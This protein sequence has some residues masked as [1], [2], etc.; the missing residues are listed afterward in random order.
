M[1]RRNRILKLW[2]LCS[3]TLSVLVPGR[4]K[5][6]NVS[7]RTNLAWDAVAEPNLGLE[8]QAGDHWSVGADAGLKAWP[9]WL[10]W[11]WDSNNTVHWRNFAVVPEVRYYFDQVFRGFFAG[12]DAVY[13]HYNVGNVQFPFGLYPEAKDYRLQGSF[14]GGGLFMGYAWW[15]GSHWRMELE[16]GAAG[17][18]AAYDRYDCAHC[19][20]KL[21]EERKVAVVPKLAVNVAWNP[22]SREKQMA[23]QPRQ[24]VVSGRDTIT[25]LTPPV[26]FVVQL[27]EVKA[28]MTVADSLAKENPWIIPIEKYRP[29]TYLDLTRPASD[30]LLFVNY[31][32]N[33]HVLRRSYMDNAAILDR[34][35]GAVEAIRD[36]A[37]TD[38]L[39]ISVV[40]LASI[41]GPQ[42]LNDTLSVRRARAVAEYIGSRTGL[43]RRQFDVI[44]KGEA[45]DW[46]KD[47]LKTHPEGN[48]KLIEIVFNEPDPDT[49]EKKIKEDPALYQRV[50]EEFL[51]DQRNSG[52]IR[53]YY[54][55]QPDAVSLKWNG[56][57]TELLKAKQYAQAV[58]MIEA[59]AALLARVEA[60]AEAA[61]AYGIALYFTALDAR[62]EAREADA[63]RWLDAAAGKGSVAARHNLEGTK[64]Y[65]PARKEF[66]AWQ[67]LMQ[68]K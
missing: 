62:D 28:P 30:S 56:P 13:T 35:Q 21:A 37:T 41:E 58:R 29:L 66:E 50:K 59:D 3:F 52:Y 7:V 22:V 4:V 64:V 67:E 8:I 2:L 47:Q 6:Q 9:R 39:M 26:A 68:E 60:D 46:F 43:A 33:S 54:S 49:R 36:A 48:E 32:L 20:T 44:G 40:G 51:A 11:D 12:A 63:L 24:L 17:G 38:E 5:A 34:M 55:N 31:E 45:W 57:V 1:N 61:N 25:V 10:A 18:L 53:V 65:G 15:M 42:R 27:K 16:A 23:S 19:G 14:W